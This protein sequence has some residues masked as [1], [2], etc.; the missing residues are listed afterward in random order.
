MPL[1]PTSLDA[2]AYTSVVLGVIIFLLIVS[3][4]D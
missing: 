1:I 2:Y 4:G 3:K